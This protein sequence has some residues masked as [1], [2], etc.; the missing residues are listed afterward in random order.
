MK[1]ESIKM[2][3]GQHSQYC[4]CEQCSGNAPRGEI[5]C[6]CFIPGGVQCVLPMYHAEEHAYE[7]YTPFSTHLAV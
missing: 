1:T 3:D 2:K 5:R 4:K 6:A 7:P